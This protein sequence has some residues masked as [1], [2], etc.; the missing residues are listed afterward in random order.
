[1]SNIQKL[2]I[3]F[4]TLKRFMKTDEDMQNT[5]KRIKS[6]GYDSVYIIGGGDEYRHIVDSIKNANL[7]IIGTTY[8]AKELFSNTKEI[9]E[10]CEY[11][12]SKEIGIY[13]EVIHSD[14]LYYKFCK[15]INSFGEE[16]AK[17][18]IK[19]VYNHHAR[20]FVRMSN[21]KRGIEIL[22]EE[23]NPEYVSF[24]LNTF[25]MQNAG[26]DIRRFISDFSGRINMIRMQDADI[27]MDYLRKSPAIG[28]GNMY[29]DGILEEA[30]KAGAE[31]FVVENEK[32]LGDLW[33]CLEKSS[34]FIHK[35]Y[36]K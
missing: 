33:E 8:N 25:W 7:E 9:L 36:M 30:Q 18:N 23:T 19:L 31:H 21:G 34:E 16:F 26:I 3:Q 22:K 13:K 2:G 6:M 32:F 17:K 28:S 5:L 1:M 10:N 12:G 4:F 27:D 20:E 11:S 14:E 35:H 15:D 29:W 24:A